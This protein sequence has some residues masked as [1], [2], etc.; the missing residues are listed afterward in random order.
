M[1][2]SRYGKIC[3]NEMNRNYIKLMTSD[4][5]W[6][7]LLEKPHCICFKFFDEQFVGVEMGKIKTL[8]NKPFYIGLRVLE[9]SKPHLYRFHHDYF[10]KKYPAEKMLFTDTESLMFWVETAG[11]YKELFAERAHFDFASGDKAIPFFIASKNKV[12]GN[13]KD[14]ANSKRITEFIGLRQKIYT[15][16][17]DKDQTTETHRAKGSKG[18]LRGKSG[19]NS[20][21]IS[22]SALWRPTCRTS[23]S[24]PLR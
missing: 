8:I 2:N 19:S 23:R 24:T 16:I 14:K 9:L 10:M 20:R 4:Q 5:K 11:I 6:N 17:D 7:K 3:E 12:I 21:W 15:L 22:S 13:F 1:N 18:A